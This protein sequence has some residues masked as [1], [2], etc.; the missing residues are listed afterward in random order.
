MNGMVKRS[1]YWLS[2]LLLLGFASRSSAQYVD[3]TINPISALTGTAVV[4]VEVPVAPLIGV[5]LQ[6]SYFFRARRPWTPNFSTRGY[7][8]GVLGHM[9]FDSEAEHTEWSLFAYGRYLN[10]FYEDADPEGLRTIFDRDNYTLSKMA[11]G[12]GGSYKHLVGEHFVFSTGVG[13]GRNFARK[14]VRQEG[15]TGDFLSLGIQERTNI[16][17]YARLTIG[18]RLGRSNKPDLRS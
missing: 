8:V 18:Y 2:F 10:V 5:E 6:S 7:R 9:Y 17:V 12:F 13:L 4:M 1:A 15:N 3:L 11:I 14:L 16:D